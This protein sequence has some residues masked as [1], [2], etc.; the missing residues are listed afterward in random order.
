M[1]ETFFLAVFFADYE[2]IA[3]YQISHDIKQFDIKIRD[4]YCFNHFENYIP[5]WP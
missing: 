5:S 4:G 1:N 3:S 2:A